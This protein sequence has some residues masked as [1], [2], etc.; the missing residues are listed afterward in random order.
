MLCSIII[1]NYNKSKYLNRC[2]LSAIRQTYKN[3]EIIFSDN[4]SSD[5]S[6]EI[7]KKF[8]TI[9]IIKTD[10]STKYSALNQIEVILKGFKE[11]SG[12]YIFLLDSD[13]FFETDKVQKIIDFRCLNNFEFISDVPRLYIDENN[14]KVFKTE[15]ILNFLRSWPII[16]P[17]SSISFSRSFFI[18]FK[19]YLFE[20]KFEKLEIDA[21][22]NFFSHIQNKKNLFKDKILTNYNQTNDGIMSEY[23]KFNSVWW[24]KRLQAH[25]YL[26]EIQYLNKKRVFK[27]LDYYVTKFINKF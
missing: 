5:N 2:L 12:D 7:V 21:R 23:K 3:I 26:H 14:S 20:N 9:K 13:D 19:N 22:L 1:S 8:E 4:G 17:T 24:K 16:F 25:M 27:N 6:I 18:N 11:S 15:K 10:R